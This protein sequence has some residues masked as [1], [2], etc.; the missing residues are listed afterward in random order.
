MILSLAVLALVVLG[1]APRPV[2][3]GQRLRSSLVSRS[4]AERNGLMRA[5]QA[6][7]AMDPA[8][9]RLAEALLDDGLLLF[10]TQRAMVHALDGETGATLWAERLGHAEYSSLAIDANDK[11][12]AVVNGST[13]Y[14][15]DRNDGR[16]VMRHRISSIP[17]IGPTITSG[18]VYIPTMKG[19]IDSYALPDQ[20]DETDTAASRLKSVWRH[21]SVG[22]VTSPLQAMPE[23]ICWTTSR[24]YLYVATIDSRRTQYRAEL[25]DSVVAPIVY[26]PPYLIVGSVGGKVYAVD[27]KSGDIAWRF[28]VQGPIS[29]PLVVVGDE[30]YVCVEEQGMFCLRADSGALLWRAPRPVG[31]VAAS[32][33]RIVSF[34][35]SGRL[36]ALDPASGSRVADLQTHGISRFLLNRDTDRIYLVTDAGLVQCLHQIDLPEPVRHRPAPA[37]PDE[38]AAPAKKAAAGATADSGAAEPEVAAEDDP[39]ATAAEG[40]EAKEE[41]AEAAAGDEKDVAEDEKEAAGDEKEAAE[42]DNP[43][44]AP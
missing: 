12:V 5:W 40:S 21:H 9:V 18:R 31:F 1:P 11:Y 42:D 24:G 19:F 6:Q 30:L 7:I 26:H 35:A 28:A 2:A 4:A 29:A 23:N 36:L 33:T 38:E 43:F 44:A 41:D 37:K 22:Q 32:P 14:V 20:E 25:G 27:E 34:D 8:R 39:F 15:V 17:I 16:E 10:V 13:L 3:H